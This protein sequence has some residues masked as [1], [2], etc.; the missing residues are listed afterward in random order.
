MHPMQITPTYAKQVRALE[1]GSPDM[2]SKLPAE[3]GRSK[4]RGVAAAVE[5]APRPV[6]RRLHPER[7]PVRLPSGIP[8]YT[9]RPQL[10]YAKHGVNSGASRSSD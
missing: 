2:V 4:L 9:G 8:W 3:A 5:A 10:P 1:E 6:V 7:D